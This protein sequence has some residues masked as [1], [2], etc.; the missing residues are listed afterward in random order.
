MIRLPHIDE[1]A[2]KEIDEK[3]EAGRLRCATCGHLATPEKVYGSSAEQK[4]GVRRGN[5]FPTAD[6]P[7]LQ[8]DSC[9]VRFVR[10]SQRVCASLGVGSERP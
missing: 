10:R 2:R 4:S 3:L 7:G 1:D 6:G 5:S 8:P 9:R